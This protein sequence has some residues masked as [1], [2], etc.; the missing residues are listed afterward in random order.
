MKIKFFRGIDRIVG[1]LLIPIIW[2]LSLPFPKSKLRTRSILIVKLWALGESVLTLPLIHAIKTKY[3]GASITVLAREKVHSV[4]TE[5]KDI[6]EVKSAEVFPL[7]ALFTKF[8]KYDVVIDCEPYL[9]ESALLSW[10]L[11]NNV[12][13]RTIRAPP[14]WC[15]WAEKR[16]CFGLHSVCDVHRTRIVGYHQ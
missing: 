7:I 4:Y 5:N 3:P 1:K 2:F 12:I 15:G 14:N 13:A 9:N 10:W 11:V 6:S 8:K 16:E